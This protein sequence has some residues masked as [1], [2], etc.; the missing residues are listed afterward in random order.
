[1]HFISDWNLIE[2]CPAHLPIGLCILRRWAAT[3]LLI[4]DFI[5]RPTHGC[6]EHSLIRVRSSRYAAV[7]VM[8]FARTLAIFLDQQHSACRVVHPVRSAASV[9]QVECQVKLSICKIAA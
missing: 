7:L 8:C 2:A 3:R 6:A 4:P 5:S 1:M 9:C